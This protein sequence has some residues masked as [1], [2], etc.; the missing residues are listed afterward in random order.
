MRYQYI[1]NKMI[2]RYGNSLEG[3]YKILIL[4]L[5]E[6]GGHDQRI[7]RQVDVYTVDGR[8]LS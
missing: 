8:V 6:P 7:I 4:L 2:I 1:K 5:P 3:M